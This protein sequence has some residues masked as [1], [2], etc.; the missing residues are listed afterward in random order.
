MS[1][2]IQLSSLSGR[3]FIVTGTTNID[4]IHASLKST[5]DIDS[6]DDA[7]SVG[8]KMDKTRM[9]LSMEMEP[10]TIIARDVQCLVET[11]TVQ[12]KLPPKRTVRMGQGTLDIVIGTTTTVSDIHVHCVQSPIRIKGNPFGTLEI[13][14]AGTV[15]SG[16][17]TT[18]HPVQWLTCKGIDVTCTT[19]KGA[20]PKGVISVNGLCAHMEMG[21]ILDAMKLI[22]TF[23][24]MVPLSSATHKK[25][26][27]AISIEKKSTPTTLE[28]SRVWNI[29]LFET[30]C[31]WQVTRS[32]TIC[33][34]SDVVRG[35]N[36]DASGTRQYERCLWL[37]CDD[38]TVKLYD[39]AG[40]ETDDDGNDGDGDGERKTGIKKQ[41]TMCHI[42]GMSLTVPTLRS[43]S[44]APPT[45]SLASKTTI[46]LTN[47]MQFGTTI[48]SFLNQLGVAKSILSGSSSQKVA[49]ATTT[50]NIS[51]TPT[52]P[53]TTSST[54]SPRFAMTCDDL[55]FSIGREDD[56]WLHMK[57]LLVDWTTDKTRQKLLHEF[58]STIDGVAASTALSHGFAMVIGGSVSLKSTLL[59]VAL[60]KDRHPVDLVSAENLHIHGD[61]LFTELNPVSTLTSQIQVDMPTTLRKGALEWWKHTLSRSGMP[62][63]IHHDLK[64]ETDALTI[65]HGVCLNQDM[66]WMDVALQHFLP[67]ST[68]VWPKLKWWDNLRYMFHGVFQLK[69][70]RM[71]MVLFGPRGTDH[72]TTE[73]SKHVHFECNDVD[74]LC[75]KGEII[76]S[77]KD[78]QLSMG[79]VPKNEVIPLLNID[80]LK[81][82][83]QWSWTCLEDMA[84]YN[85][86]VHLHQ[87]REEKDLFSHFRSRGMTLSLGFSTL[88]GKTLLTM[89]WNHASWLYEFINMYMLTPDE[90]QTYHGEDLQITLSYPLKCLVIEVET[91]ALTIVWLSEGCVQERT[92]QESQSLLATTK[93]LGLTLRMAKEASSFDSLSMNPIALI[94]SATEIYL[95]SPAV[96]ISAPMSSV[97][98]AATTVPAALRSHFTSLV[99][100]TTAIELGMGTQANDRLVW[101]CS[102]CRGLSSSHSPA[103]L[104]HDTV[105]FNETRL[106][107]DIVRRDALSSILETIWE[108]DDDKSNEEEK[109]QMPE[110]VRNGPYYGQAKRRSTKQDSDL[111]LL[112]LLVERASKESTGSGAV[113]RPSSPSSP[114]STCSSPSPS[115]HRA[116]DRLQSCESIESSD[117][118]SSSSRRSSMDLFFGENGRNG[119]G[120]K[121]LTSFEL[122]FVTPQ[123]RLQSN[124]SVV[125]L[126]M[127]DANVNWVNEGGEGGERAV[128]DG[129][130]GGDNN[131]TVDSDAMRV[132]C[133]DVV[134]FVTDGKG[135]IGQNMDE[136]DCLRAPSLIV[137]RTTQQGCP[138][139]SVNLPSLHATTDSKEYHDVVDVVS[140]VILAPPMVMKDTPEKDIAATLE[141]II[142]SVSDEENENGDH[143][144]NVQTNLTEE[145]VHDASSN[146]RSDGNNGRLISTIKYYVREFIW[147]IVPPSTNGS[148]QVDMYKLSGRH[149]YYSILEYSESELDIYDISVQNLKPG[150]VEMTTFEDPMSILDIIVEDRKDKRGRRR[151]KFLSVVSSSRT[152]IP[153]D[154]CRLPFPMY[155]CLEINFFPGA[156]G[157]LQ[158]QI[159]SDVADALNIFFGT[160]VGGNGKEEESDETASSLLLGRS[161]STS[162]SSSP[163]KGPSVLLPTV[164]TAQ[165]VEAKEMIFLRKMRVSEITFVLCARN[166]AVAIPD[167][168]R[169]RIKAM[170]M[171]SIVT[172]FTKLGNMIVMNSVRKVATSL[173]LKNGAKTVIG[174][175]TGV[176]FKA[177]GSNAT[178]KTADTEEESAAILFGK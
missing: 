170:Q 16:D 3:S 128:E 143:N 38:T 79:I 44:S 61:L 60:G 149:D 126:N 158:L 144:T 138:T 41:W 64:I 91:S 56:L 82:V 152:V 161:M 22:S 14:S 90:Y 112:S 164:A 72:P 171:N 130:N 54:S 119:S 48:L 151:V 68:S 134:G 106:I 89:P 83:I 33:I 36:G 35:T 12:L 175:L 173:L 176:A 155:E 107:F 115:H 124:D 4:T 140:N 1:S 53:P 65:G 58:M 95:P 37:D 177:H 24:E 168:W 113:M 43:S 17:G 110:Y 92:F 84:P 86:Y 46:T 172:D 28:Q 118:V 71:Y 129:E 96:S 70:I 18:E 159:T 125:V 99:A 101:C 27:V 103:T 133:T 141:E 67:P 111:D 75:S 147:K 47:D 88:S 76:T 127:L 78:I 94:T 109:K 136:H 169:V 105:R 131:E 104:L 6:I 30:C 166:F 20:T 135:W 123:V 150:E 19:R 69:S 52:S 8:S 142:E 160:T 63:K 59:R 34:R 120:R 97:C 87:N 13:S 154:T 146:I 2:T 81:C 163:T 49:V 50:S 122:C 39:N 77:L 116:R 121:V 139:L 11:T 7:S 10:T 85:H 132:V 25:E 23:R 40:N 26:Q 45:L 114:L 117:G 156:T 66:V 57:D 165:D 93:G 21:T 9:L 42:P 73:E 55:T 80:S 153:T 15:I 32:K 100:S 5:I 102:H 51:L 174:S 31:K 62:V 167:D 178:M 137:S 74:I 108:V 162:S 148:F 29:T 157:V 145:E 98:I